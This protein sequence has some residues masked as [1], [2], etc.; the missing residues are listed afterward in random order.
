MNVQNTKQGCLPETQEG[1]HA[2]KLFNF[3]DVCVVGYQHLKALVVIGHVHCLLDEC[4]FLNLACKT[5]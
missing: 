4:C 1:V 3:Q 2:V 5:Q